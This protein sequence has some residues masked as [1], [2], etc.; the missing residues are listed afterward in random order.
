MKTPEGAAS[1]RNFFVGL[2]PI[3]FFSSAA[4]PCL[5]FPYASMNDQDQAQRFFLIGTEQLFNMTHV[6]SV[7]S[8]ALT[9]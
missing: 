1:R 4:Q 3:E 8:Y 7:N 9:K 5:F 6:S 2:V